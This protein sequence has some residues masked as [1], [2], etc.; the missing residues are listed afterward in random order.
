MQNQ[1]HNKIIRVDGSEQPIEGR[2]SIA[3]ISKLIGADVLGTVNLRDGRVML[4][5][6][7]GVANGRT[8]NPA[9]TVLYHGVCIP[10]T[11]HKI[12]GDVAI[13]LD[14]DFA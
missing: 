13:V 4:L 8:P 14:A 9:A 5:D 2:P 6:D 12:H 3:G 10:G 1:Q 7:N 11:T